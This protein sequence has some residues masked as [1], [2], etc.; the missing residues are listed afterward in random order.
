MMATHYSDKVAGD[1]M[2]RKTAVKAIHAADGYAD[3]REE[4]AAY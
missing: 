3:R 1:V 2:D 4:L